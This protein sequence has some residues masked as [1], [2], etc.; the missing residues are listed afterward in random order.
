MQLDVP[1]QRVLQRPA[2]DVNGCVRGPLIS[3]HKGP[4][5]QEGD[6]RRLG[7]AWC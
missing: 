2:I 3:T 6:N 4:V 1:V 7:K 5:F